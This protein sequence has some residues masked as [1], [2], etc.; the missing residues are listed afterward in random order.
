MLLELS[1]QQVQLLHACLA[2]SIE[3]LHDEVLH[4]DGHEMRAELRE[5]LHQLQGI[6]RQV[7]SLLPRE[8]V[9]A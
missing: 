9:P 5:Q 1:P 8:Q 7:E 2:E 3:D 4:T 6:Q